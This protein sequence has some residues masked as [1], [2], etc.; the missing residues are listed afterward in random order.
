[1]VQ[2]TDTLVDDAEHEI[3]QSWREITAKKVTI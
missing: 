3:Q 2:S 1:M